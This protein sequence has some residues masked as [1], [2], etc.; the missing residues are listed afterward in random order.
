MLP[1]LRDVE[2]EFGQNCLPRAT[3]GHEPERTTANG[4]HASFERQLSPRQTLSLGGEV[5]FEKLSSDSFDVN[6]TTG[7]ESPRRPRV[8]SGVSY[9]N[10]GIFARTEFQLVPDRLRL[11]GALRWG[12]ASYEAKASDAP[13][14]NGLPLWPDDSLSTNDV[15]FR[16]AAVASPLQDWTFQTSFSRGYRAPHMTDLGTLGLT[17]SGFEVAAPD[18]A[19]LNGFV[20]DSAAANA[21]STGDPVQQ[22]TSETSL[23]FD[24]SARY[25]TQEGSRRGRLLRESHL[26]QHPEAGAHP[27]SRSGRYG[28][29]RT[30]HHLP[31]RDRHGARRALLES[32]PRSRQLRQRSGLGHRA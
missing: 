22:V 17:G 21:V 28:H 30:A 16:A 31:E 24:A 15:T 4:V 20:G 23:N 5:Y 26:R 12:G 25:G 18:V 29:R 1:D 3:I 32:R 10:G 14:V 19:G 27:A 7:A 2:H 9:L 11:V 8:P 6:P 13:V